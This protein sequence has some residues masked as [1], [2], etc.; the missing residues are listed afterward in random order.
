VA[1]QRQDTQGHE[2][3]FKCR[4]DNRR[5]HAGDDADQYVVRSP[6]HYCAFR[7]N[8]RG[9]FQMTLERFD[10]A[11][12]AEFQRLAG[13][14]A[15]TL[16]PGDAVALSGELGAGKTTF[17]RAAV[18]RLHGS[19]EATS[20]TFTFRHTYAGDPPVEHLDLYR[21]DDPAEAVEIGLYEAFSTA[22][23]TFVEWP[24]RLPSLLPATAIRVAIAGSGDAPRRVEIARPA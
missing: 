11:S 2:E 7:E 15:G 5:E 13:A 18:R 17:V 4:G 12:P 6:R 10:A 22:A 23:I 1:T 21:L 20:P 19:D 14:F 9:F 8:E 3:R 16:R 24:E